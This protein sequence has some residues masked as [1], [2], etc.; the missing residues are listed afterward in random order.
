[1]GGRERLAGL[2]R[3]HQILCRVGRKLQR[4]PD[5]LATALHDHRKA[6]AGASCPDQAL[7]LDDA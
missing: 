4:A 5:L 7:D 1:L 2:L 3:R 6:L